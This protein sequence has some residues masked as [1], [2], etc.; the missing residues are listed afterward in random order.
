MLNLLAE[1]VSTGTQTQ[2]TCPLAVFFWLPIESGKL[3]HVIFSQIMQ[4]FINL[5]KG[6]Q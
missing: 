4:L 1:G 3:N 2:F 5:E 6:S